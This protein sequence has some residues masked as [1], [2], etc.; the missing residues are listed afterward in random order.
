M[1]RLEMRPAAGA[2]FLLRR[3]RSMA[4]R[5][6]DSG[7]SRRLFEHDCHDNKPRA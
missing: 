3:G 2:F 6:A 4:Y 5:F 7:L 1:L